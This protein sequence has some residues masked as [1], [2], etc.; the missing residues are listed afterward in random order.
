MLI[1]ADGE[2]SVTSRILWHA[3]RLTMTAEINDA[4]SPKTQRA[5]LDAVLLDRLHRVLSDVAG[6]E[7]QRHD[8]GVVAHD[9][10]R[11]DLLRLLLP[12]LLEIGRASCR[13]RV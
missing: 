12:G 1:R 8:A 3:S 2:A 11:R 7:E 4:S 6:D 5:R 13:E 10:R 9:S